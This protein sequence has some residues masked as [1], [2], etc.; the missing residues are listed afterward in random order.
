MTNF[1]SET[2]I[3]TLCD[4]VAQL[5]DLQP[6]LAHSQKKYHTKINQETPT[7][8]LELVRKVNDR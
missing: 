6:V 4:Q 5:P 2:E 7:S 8:I 1:I 3:R